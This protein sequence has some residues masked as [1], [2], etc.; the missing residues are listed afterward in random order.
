MS[1]Q[2]RKRFP[3]TGTVTAVLVLLVP[4]VG[5]AWW[6]NQ[7]KGEPVIP[8]PAL[9]EL[10]V[11]C[12]GRVDGLRPVAHIDPVMPGKIVA[13]YVVEGQHVSPNEKL[14]KLDD[15]SLKLRVEEA[16]AALTAADL[17][18]DAAR[19]EQKL[20]P[21]RRATQEAALA[22]ATDRVAASRRVLDEKKK[23][24]TFGTVTATEL[25][26]A[27][28]EVKQYEQ[29]EGVERSRLEEVRLADPGLKFRAA[30]AKRTM[31][32]IAL[33]Q[34]EKS[35]RDCVLLAPAAGTIL[36]VQTSAGETVAPGTVQPPIVFR[37]DG[38]LIVRTELEQ[39]FIGRVKPGMKATIRDD[40]RADSPTWTGTVTQLGQVVA[41]KRSIL[42]EPGEV[43]DVRTVEC[44][45]SLDGDTA[46]L[47]VGQRMRVRIGRGE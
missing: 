34:A 30:E 28:S 45:V 14:L 19:Q 5:V 31:A 21:I 29:L 3:T 20:Q 10:D 15:E 25:I 7:P 33:K 26:A 43:N 24:N 23:A 4:L 9:S 16:Q 37:P 44:V 2:P 12:R 47:L 8:G 17:E 36:R 35:V 42:L 32:G 40:V 46:G 38:P 39:E 18:L 27:E 11:V 41:R 22:A 13:V 6:L 1:E